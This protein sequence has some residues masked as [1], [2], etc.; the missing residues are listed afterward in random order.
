MSFNFA[1][2]GKP[3]RIIK[4]G[5]YDKKV[6]SLD[7]DI[8]NNDKTSFKSLKIA[9]DSKFQQVPN[10]KSEREILYITG[11][12]GSGKSTYTRMYLEQYK[13][14]YKQHPIYMFSSLAEDSSLDSIKP[15]RFKIDDKLH[16]D[17][18]DVK[19]LADS[20]V[21]FDDIDVIS[22]KKIKEA[23]YNIL[24]QVLEIGR[25]YKISC[26]VTN[27]LPTNGN[28][29]RRILNESS[30][31]VYFPASSSGKI[32]YV[33]TEY[34]DI[35][36]KQIKYFKNCNSRWICIYKNFPMYFISE[37]EITLLNTQDSDDD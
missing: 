11:R 1:N 26:I 7:P 12:S 24:N 30:C 31:F 21:I 23:V 8:N 19:D 14:K 32:K 5:K 36:K 10:T 16:E 22:N 3:V 18:I 13:K 2:A 33:L 20:C 15:K 34:L 4:G 17:P 29:T 27:H 25:H 37:H 28:W 6:I 35:D 9:N